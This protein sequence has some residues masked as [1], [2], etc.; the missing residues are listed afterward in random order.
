[1]KAYALLEQL[2][3]EGL[4]APMTIYRALDALIARGLARKIASLNAF[5]AVRAA[6]AASSAAYVTCRRCGETLKIK[7]DAERL[8]DLF[9]AEGFALNGLVIE[10]S[11]EC[12]REGCAAT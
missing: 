11:G 8:R 2:H 1:M 3:D 4:K 10:A 6:D 7:L 12:V 9:G 5:V